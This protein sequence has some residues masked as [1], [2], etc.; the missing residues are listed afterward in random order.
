MKKNWNLKKIKFI[1]ITLKLPAI[2]IHNPVAETKNFS[3][4][5]PPTMQSNRSFDCDSLWKNQE[6][7]FR[8]L[9]VWIS[10]LVKYISFFGNFSTIKMPTPEQK[11]FATWIPFFICNFLAWDLGSKKPTHCSR[12]KIILSTEKIRKTVL[13]NFPTNVMM[14]TRNEPISFQSTKSRQS[15]GFWRGIWWNKSGLFLYGN[16]IWIQDKSNRER[17]MVFSCISTCGPSDPNADLF[18]FI[19]WTQ[20]IKI[21]KWDV[22]G[23]NQLFSCREN[24]TWTSRWINKKASSQSFPTVRMAIP[25]TNRKP[26]KNSPQPIQSFRLRLPLEKR[27]A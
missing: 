3:K 21:S 1:S 12:I 6:L 22:Y 13:K 9:G 26:S 5:S 18:N 4:C 10:I 11:S 17:C 14:R 8:K 19:G 27:G 16:T 25:E 24:R 7:D 15:G 2:R 20:K 23:R